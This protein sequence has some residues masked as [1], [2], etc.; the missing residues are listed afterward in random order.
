MVAH[1]YIPISGA[2]VK[3]N[4]ICLWDSQT[5]WNSEFKFQLEVNNDNILISDEEDKNNEGD[6]HDDDDDD[7]KVKDTKSA[8]WLRVLATKPSDGDLSWTHTVEGD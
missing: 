6:D 3:R 8:Q 1:A 2:M 7:D 5:K 4:S